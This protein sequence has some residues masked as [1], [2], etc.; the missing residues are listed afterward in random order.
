MSFII[1]KLSRFFNFNIFKV[2][3]ILELLHIHNFPNLTTVTFSRLLVLGET[4]NKNSPPN[5]KIVT[6]FSNSIYHNFFSL[7]NLHYSFCN[8]S[9]ISCSHS[10]NWNCHIFIFFLDSQTITLLK[11]QHI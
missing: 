5:P 3:L 9:T 1:L 10:P 2:L 4:W 8:S 11:D 7:G 6:C